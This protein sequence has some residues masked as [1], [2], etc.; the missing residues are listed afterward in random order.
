MKTLDVRHLLHDIGRTRI[1]STT[2]MA[3]VP[4]RHTRVAMS[5]DQFIRPG[6]HPDINYNIFCSWHIS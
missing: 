3:D 2:R 5:N 4:P 6:L 1:A